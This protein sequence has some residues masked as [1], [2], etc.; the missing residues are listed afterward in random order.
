M[1]IRGLLIHRS[2]MSPLGG[3]VSGLYARYI[4]HLPWDCNKDVYVELNMSHGPPTD[5]NK[6]PKPQIQM[7]GQGCGIFIT[8][9]GRSMRGVH[10][11]KL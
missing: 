11:R 7:T 3:V 4:H 8:S 10:G 5:G 6:A 9:L 1:K 2:K